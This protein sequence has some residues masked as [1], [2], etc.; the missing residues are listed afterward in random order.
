M[1]GYATIKNVFAQSS[2]VFLSS[3][4]GL[5]QRPPSSGKCEMEM[6]TLTMSTS[7]AILFCTD[8]PS[9]GNNC[10]RYIRVSVPRGAWLV[11][12]LHVCHHTWSPRKL[13]SCGHH[14]ISS[15]KYSYLHGKIPYV[16]SSCLV[17]IYLAEQSTIPQRLV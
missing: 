10:Y 15:R 16:L 8:L 6:V 7:D 12:N 11:Q 2:L 17:R 9:R 14:F 3:S 4:R 13:P 5:Q 1:A